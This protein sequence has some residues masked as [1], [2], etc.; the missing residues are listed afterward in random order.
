MIEGTNVTSFY[1]G[2]LFAVAGLIV[3]VVTIVMED[4]L[5]TLL[6]AVG[7]I[8]A[9]ALEVLAVRQLK[10]AGKGLR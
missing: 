3:A 5:S 7:F 6:G 1:K 4:H 10:A 9:F 8:A 2:G